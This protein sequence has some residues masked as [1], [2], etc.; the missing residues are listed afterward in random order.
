M[1]TL[2]L[3]VLTAK[4]IPML[5]YKAFELTG[6]DLH[7]AFPTVTRDPGF[8]GLIR[9]IVHDPRYQIKSSCTTSKG[10]EDLF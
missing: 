3:P 1:E 9:K 6:R 8:C 7:R 2:S 5:A 4:V 10:T